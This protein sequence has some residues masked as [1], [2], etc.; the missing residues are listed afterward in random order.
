ML[1]IQL[2]TSFVLLSKTFHLPRPDSASLPHFYVEWTLLSS[3]IVDLDLCCPVSHHDLMEDG[4]IPL[5]TDVN[6]LCQLKSLG[7]RIH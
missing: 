1:L 6:D 4:F 2:L 7:V 5:C 3:G